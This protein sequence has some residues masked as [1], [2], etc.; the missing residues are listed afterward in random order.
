MI[1]VRYQKLSILLCAIFLMTGC[2]DMQSTEEQLSAYI[3]GFPG[4]TIA[5]AVHDLQS[6]QSIDV[7]GDSV[8]HAASTMKLPVMMK[9]YDL[10]DE[11][12]ISL[13]DSLMLENRFSSIVDGS[14][15]AIEDDSDDAI[16]ERLGT[17]MSLAD[18]MHNMI[19]VSSNLA[20]NILIDFVSADSVQAYIEG[21]GTE[22]MRVLRGV[23]DIKAYEAG[24]SNT[25]TAND[26][27]VLLLA[28]ATQNGVSASAADAM[29][30]IMLAQQFNSMIPA[31]V[32]EG[33]G[34]AHKTG[35]IT[36]IKHDAAIVYPANGE[37]YILVVLTRGFDNPSDSER[38]VKEITELVHKNIRPQ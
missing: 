31:G 37:P 27:S 22:H 12:R 9:L 16:Y 1:Y 28:I 11:G 18:L 15:Y 25:A 17:K 14:V 36:R 2:T 38:V 21:L 19:T 33:T 5:V 32:P 30:D 26:L 8:F 7:N 13:D 24:L 23:E 29:V 34:V 3:E 6:G 35:S 20:T 4:T 10:F